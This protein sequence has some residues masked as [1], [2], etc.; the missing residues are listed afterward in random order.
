MDWW[1]AYTALTVDIVRRAG[2]PAERITC[3]NNA[4]DVRRLDQD[5]RAAT[6]E[7]IESVKARYGIDERSIVGLFCGS[8]Y[9]DKKLALLFAACDMI[10]AELPHFRLLILGDGAEGAYVKT[11]VQQ[12]DWAHW[13]GVQHGVSKAIAFGL[14]QAM[15]NPGLVGLH[16]LDAFSMGLP[17][18]TTRTARHSPEIAYLDE[19]VNGLMVEE[20]AAAYA[21]ATIELLCDPSR[22][23]AMRAA[24]LASARR[25]TIEAMA[26]N[27]MDGLGRA[28]DETPIVR[29]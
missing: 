13:D 14:A 23:A 3:L 24:A 21:S 26:A 25:Y 16:I 9:G 22:L 29:P 17:M 1:F 28:I 7:A 20:D 4:I 6:P 11:Q 27:F 12:R 5:W 15:L 10:H 2:F 8:L 19:G 18:I